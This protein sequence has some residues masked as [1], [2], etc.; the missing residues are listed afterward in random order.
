[1]PLVV[2]G[3]GLI[4]AVFIALISAVLP[5]SKAARL[6]VADALAGR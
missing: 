6:P 2:I 3:S 1:M 5:A 4:G